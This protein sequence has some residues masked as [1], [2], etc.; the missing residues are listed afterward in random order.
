[1]LVEEGRSSRRTHE[2]FHTHLETLGRQGLD[3]QYH[4]DKFVP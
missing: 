4:D 1:M 2:L 3:D